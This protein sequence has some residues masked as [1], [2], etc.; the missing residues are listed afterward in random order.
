MAEP[1]Q[2]DI[3]DVARK[4]RAKKAELVKV[5]PT[6]APVAPASDT[7][8][9]DNSPMVL[10]KAAL[11][12]GA[13]MAV[14]E[15]LM[16]LQERWEGNQARKA[17][18]AAMAAAR[19]EIKPILKNRLV[20]HDTKAGGRKTYRHEDLAE[21]ARS[22]DPVLAR[23]GLSYRFRTTAEVNEP[24]RVTCVVS[25]RD[26]YSEENS[27][28]G[29][30]DESGNKNSLQSMGSTLTY[31]QRYTLKA[32]LGLAASNDDDGKASGVNECLTDEQVSSLF[33]LIAETNS[34]VDQFLVAAK[35]EPFGEG[36][37]RDIDAVRTKLAEIKGPEFKR[38]HALL[39]A[40]KRK[41]ALT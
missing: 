20:D 18:D 3:E 36:V 26:G 7:A 16:D 14:L 12:R 37:E 8:A 6:P 1:A 23:H 10:L 11:D 22:V 2:I 38:L 39:E 31:L 5:E 19:A 34:N 40:K 25:H 21:I 17:F 29:P 28:P 30:R 32:A 13:D 15:K 27:L 9:I 24:I 41:A 35:V 33:S 4:P